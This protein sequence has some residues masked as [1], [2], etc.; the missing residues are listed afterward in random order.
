MKKL[1]IASILALTVVQVATVSAADW[2][3]FRSGFNDKIKDF[4]EK[5]AEY[6]GKLVELQTQY[7]QAV[8]SG[9]QATINKFT[10]DFQ[11]KRAAFVKY[12]Q[13]KHTNFVKMFNER[14]K[15][16]GITDE[17]LKT[18]REK[19]DQINAHL[20]E[21]GVPPVRLQQVR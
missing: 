17:R 21:L 3:I 4:N 16:I 6:K 5:V 9:N 1:L 20:Q 7:Q 19:L 12:L 8:A 15:D 18:L 2:N 14:R 13:D 10:K 11:E